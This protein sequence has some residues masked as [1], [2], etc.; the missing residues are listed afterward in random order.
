MSD[1]IAIGEIID[2]EE[3]SFW[4]S[5]TK[6]EEASK[7]SGKDTYTDSQGIVRCKRCRS[8]RMC[9]LEEAG[10]WVPCACKCSSTKTDEDKP[11]IVEALKANSGL[12]GRYKE[13][14]FDLCEVTAENQ[15]V[16]ESCLRFAINFQQ[17][18]MNGYGMYLYGASGVGKTYFSACIANLLLNAGV[19]VLFANVNT[20][21][22]EIRYSYSQRGCE[23]QII[24]RYIS[25]DLVIFDDIGTEKYS[26]KSE[27]LSFAQDKFFQIIDG[28]YVRKKS[29]IFTSNYTLQQL[30]DER[31]IL[32]KTV[33]RMDEMSTRK[34]E[35]KGKQH[36]QKS[37]SSEDCPF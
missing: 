17:V 30:T 9:F 6:E 35:V 22:S 33:D 15:S 16:F 2:S 28:R 3:N 24:D 11:M 10:R 4:S 12:E 13:A 1:L 32:S 23:K 34:F 29:T 21:L 37:I 36:R 8:P 5:N 27:A 31:G 7:F 19:K 20:I 25:A 18:S 26:A 14:D